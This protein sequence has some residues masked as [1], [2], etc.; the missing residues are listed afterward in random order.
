[1]VR[2]PARGQVYWAVVDET[3]GRKPYL[4]VSNNIRNQKLA[5]CLAVRLTSSA[6]PRLET[7]VEL[8]PADRP[9]VGR[10]MCDDILLLFP[11]EDGFEPAGALS[12]A[13]MARVDRGLRVA[14]ALR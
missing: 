14:L 4:V 11:D 12:P 2:W 1:M 5:S 10:V 13:T 9:L 8:G 7:I 3:V 6:K